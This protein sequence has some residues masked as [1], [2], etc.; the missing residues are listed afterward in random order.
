MSDI[1]ALRLVGLTLVVASCQGHRS[2]PGGRTSPGGPQ[3]QL[4]DSIILEEPDSAYLGRPGPFVATPADGSYL[5]TDE[6]ADRV[7][8]FR[9]DGRLGFVL[10][11][12]GAGPRDFS[13][14][15]PVIA[16]VDSLLIVQSAGTARLTVFDAR[17]RKLLAQRLYLGN[18]MSIRPSK[19]DLLIG[20][21]D[22]AKGFGA[23]RLP[24]AALFNQ[25][26]TGPTTFIEPTFGA[27]PKAYSQYPML[28]TFGNVFAEP[29]GDSVLVGFGATSY[30]VLFDRAG[31]AVDT[32]DIP[33]R[34]RRGVPPDSVKLFGSRS[35][36]MAR[37]ATAISTLL[38]LWHLP[39]GQMLVWHQ[40][41][42]ARFKNGQLVEL[43]GRAF[44]SILDRDLTHACVDT[45]LLA[46]GTS[47]P[48]LGV[49][50][51]TLLSLD[52][53]VLT[54][55]PLRAQTVIRRYLVSSLGCHW[56]P[57]GRSH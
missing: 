53:V 33:A 42:S 44:V 16:L 26:Q 2:Q 15:G 50:G 17:S 14:V 23:A 1:T 9:K 39:D 32:I 34:E 4:L 25:P 11:R 7:L 13:S 10:G 57:I 29:V 30:L 18:L 3:V 21:F 24:I 5:L 40:D 36:P 41:P 46:P 47:R 19:A 43:T 51:D 22:L 8:S 55:G 35:M 48:R 54:N 28:V 37:L 49:R 27:L 6:L 38:G 56:I 20:D 31:Q 12:S 45:E 52:Q